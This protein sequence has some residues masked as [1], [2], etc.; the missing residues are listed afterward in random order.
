MSQ[1]DDSSRPTAVFV[2][3]GA[4]GAAMAER[5]GTSGGA[6]FSDLVLYNRTPAKAELVAARV[7][8]QASGDKTLRTTVAATVD[9]VAAAALR[10]PSG[11]VI[12]A[13]LFG[14]DSTEGFFT[15]CLKLLHRDQT[16]AVPPFLLANCATIS[17][18][19]ARKLARL[20]HEAGGAFVNAPVTGRP[21]HA[22]AGQLCSW[23]AAAGEAP[24]VAAGADAALFSSHP[25]R[26]FAERVAPLWSK[27]ARVL[28]ES[29]AGASAL[30]KLCTNLMVYGFGQV[31]G[32]TL[33]LLDAAGLP[34]DSLRDWTSHVLPAPNLVDL[35]CDKMVSRS[36]GGDGRPV[37]AALE[38][39]QKDL[40][41]M[42]GLVDEAGG[43]SS[44][45]S[46]DPPRPGAP[47][48]VL[49]GVLGEASW[50]GSSLHAARVLERLT[51]PDPFA[52]L[53]ERAARCACRPR[54]GGANGLERLP[55]GARGAGD[56]LI[57]PGVALANSRSNLF[58]TAAG[59]VFLSGVQVLRV[60]FGVA[61]GL[62][63]LMSCVVPVRART[64]NERERKQTSARDKGGRPPPHRDFARHWAGSL[65]TKQRWMDLRAAV[66]CVVSGARR[67]Q[68]GHEEQAL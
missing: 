16:A 26:V 8:E 21:P 9:E 68:A 39:A 22:A 64:T 6:I 14:D 23:V 58:S 3:L 48:P 1:S 40:R 27:H 15:A 54:G 49:D 43:S 65:G 12:V 67:E 20:V 50:G 11:V 24:G 4:M 2:G 61:V 35:Y 42:R 10:N 19:V 29:D 17:A 28:S 46:P 37:G 32:E 66:W 31:L 36:F 45:S 33:L 38:V 30:Y 7:S 47:L 5:I 53:G 56:E 41:L 25:A 34:R 55:A 62:G 57:A 52:R 63:V 51:Y 13:M 18:P 44:N 59:F 60:N